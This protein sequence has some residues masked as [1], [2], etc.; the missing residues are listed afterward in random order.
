MKNILFCL[1]FFAFSAQT[2]VKTVNTLLYE[3]SGKDLKTP[4]Y[5]YGTIHAACPD[6][7]KVTEAI[8][9]AMA[10]TKQLYLELDMD[11]PKMFAGMLTAMQMKDGHKLSDY[12]TEAE[13]E[14]FKRLFKEKTKMS[15]DMF[16]RM[17]PFML[18][19][20][21]IPAMTNCTPSAWEMKLM[22]M[23]LAEKEE[24]E[25]LEAVTAQLEIFEQ[26][27][28]EKQAKEMYKGLKEFDKGVVD[29]KKMQKLYQEQDVE[30]LYG[31]MVAD[32]FS[33]EF[34]ELMLTKRNE[35]WLKIIPKIIAEKPTFIGVGAGHLG[36]R[37][38]VLALLKAAGYTVKAI[39]SK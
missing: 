26:I 9:K 5:I 12:L 32:E 13:Y 36:G 39:E 25:G 4:S 38:G 8:K 19:S 29:F 7:M 24:V 16:Q 11:D 20:F 1:T 15:I 33:K 21:L 34:E 23:A 10:D 17:K 3:I 2:Q 14:D 18:S 22:Q 37:K 30:G 31:M 35:N 27:S 28:Y 6:D